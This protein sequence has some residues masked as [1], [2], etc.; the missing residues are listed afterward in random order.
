MSLDTLL[1]LSGVDGFAVINSSGDLVELQA[2]KQEIIDEF[3][4]KNKLRSLF[5][6]M[7]TNFSSKVLLAEKGAWYISDLPLDQGN[8]GLLVLAGTSDSVDI[9]ELLKL[10]SKIKSESSIINN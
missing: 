9:P 7:Q 8:C 4:D 5:P 6:E 2:H 1:S 10:I 3:F